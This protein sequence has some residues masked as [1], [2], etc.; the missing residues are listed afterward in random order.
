[1]AFNDK[2]NENFGNNYDPTSFDE[3]HEDTA[4]AQGEPG[5]GNPAQ[6]TGSDH[7]KVCEVCNK[8]PADPTLALGND[9][10]KTCYRQMLKTPLRWQAFIAAALAIFLSG[11]GVIVLAFTGLI[12]TH[13]SMGD[14]YAAQKQLKDALDSYGEAYQIANS[15]NSQLELENFLTYGTKSFVKEMKV[16]AIAESPLS[17]GQNLINANSDGKAFKNI[18]L[19]KLKPYNDTF[20]KFLATRDAA[21]PIFADYQDLEPKDVPYEDLVAK[22]EALATGEDADRYDAYIIE[23]YKTYAAVLADKGAQTE[24]EHMLKVKELAP[25]ASWLYGYYLAD[26]YRR[27]GDDQKIIEISDELIENN[28]NSL[29]AY[30]MKARLYAKNSDFEKAFEVSKEMKKYNENSAAAYALEC[31]LYRRQGDVDKAHELCDEGFKADKGSTELYRQLA[32]ILLLKGDKEAAYEAADEAY[33]SAYYSQDTTLELINTV[34]LCAYLAGE[35]EM[36]E[37]TVD[38]LESNGQ[39]P[40][41]NVLDI[42]EGKKTVQEVFLEGEGDVL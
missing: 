25:E 36:Y 21:E 6:A 20:E 11:V 8:N 37:E 29:E 17:V 5:A 42:I 23:Y 14:S 27:L 26:C 38:L 41:Q 12:A 16:A 1:M 7:D 32:I 24:L 40:A 22:L 4:L 19:R 35:E 28:K 2:E 34:A 15:F 9:Y 10:C 39:S 13:V 3:T 33:G 31:E 30:A 18:W